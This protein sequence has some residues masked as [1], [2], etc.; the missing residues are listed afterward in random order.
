MARLNEDRATR[1]HRS[2]LRSRLGGDAAAFLVL[3]LSVPA[4]PSLARAV[5]SVTGHVPAAWLA[6]TVLLT[7]AILVAVAL[8]RLPFDVYATGRS[9]AATRSN[10]CHSRAGSGVMHV[11]PSSADC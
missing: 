2:R 10:V 3:A 9:R 11:R 4:G 1:Y 5:T 6:A 7:A 8:A